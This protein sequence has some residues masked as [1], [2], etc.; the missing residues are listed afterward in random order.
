MA[1]VAPPPL[2]MREFRGLWI[3]TVGN[4]NWPDTQHETTKQQKDELIAIL[5]RA[6]KLHLN[7]IVLQVRPDCDALYASKIEPWSE[8]LTGTMGKNPGY[9]PLAFAV[10]EAHKRGLE[11]HAWF[12]PY[13]VRLRSLKGPIAPNH[14]SRTHPEIV[15]TYGKYLWLDP[16]EQ[17]TRDYSQSV[18]M[19]VVK[20]YDVDGIHFDDYFYPYQ[21]HEAPNPKIK[22]DKSKLIDFPDEVSWKRYLASGGKMARNDWRRENVNTFVQSVYHAIKAEKSW[23]KFGISPF[24]IWQPGY[25]AQIKGLNSYDVLYSD[26]RKWLANG[27]VDY[28]APQLYWRID[29]KEQSFPVLLKWWH[30]Q[31]PLHH[32]IWPGMEAHP[33]DEAVRQI[34]VTR[35]QSADPGVVLWHTKTIME[36]KGGIADALATNAYTRSALVPASPWLGTIPPSRPMVS[37]HRSSR[38]VKVKWKSNLTPWQWV[39]QAKINGQWLTEILPGEKKER[40]Y[41]TSPLPQSVFVSA[42]D[43]LGNVSA[44]VLA[45]GQ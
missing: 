15:R 28:L 13:R 33:A 26:S 31:N 10:A 3:A 16:T 12:N 36:N 7:A 39:V 30:E 6:V 20:R 44:P 45:G 32:H 8:V 24:G 5:D 2:P 22:G 1:E 9:D 27:W 42:V 11:L 25:P 17:A 38:E 23:V 21:E 18:I 40:V 19:D 4:S 29:A 41:K 43:R 37:A 34:Q 14:V 35:K